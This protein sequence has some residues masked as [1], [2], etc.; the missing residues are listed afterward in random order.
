MVCTI[1]QAFKY[2]VVI[3]DKKKFCDSERK[4]TN[5]KLLSLHN[6]VPKIQQMHEKFHVM[7]L[8]FEVDLNLSLQN[9]HQ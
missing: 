5:K 2:L 8:E 9:D 1:E 6:N 4:Q 7:T 3:C